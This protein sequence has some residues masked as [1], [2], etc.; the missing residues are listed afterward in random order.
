MLSPGETP[1]SAE[2]EARAAAGSAALAKA[3]AAGAFA[4]YE[5]HASAGG[6]ACDGDD[7]DGAPACDEAAEAEV[8]AAGAQGE[9]GEEEEEEAAAEAAEGDDAFPADADGDLAAAAADATAAFEDGHLLL[10]TTVDIGGGRSDRVEVRA[11]DDPLALARAFVERHGL[12]AAIVGALGRH[13]LD[14]LREAAAAQEA[15]LYEAEAAGNEEGHEEAYE[16][17]EGEY[18]EEEEEEGHEG[19]G[20]QH[21]HHLRP[22]R[23]EASGTLGRPRRAGSLGAARSGALVDG[24]G[25]GAAGGA[26][27]EVFERLYE[28]AVVLRQKLESRRAVK[29][30][31]DALALRSGRQHMGWISSEMM[32]QRNA[33]PYGNYGEM[34]YAESLEG[35]ARREQRAARERAERGEAEAAEATFR[36][37]ISRLAQQL[38]TRAE[39]AAPAWQRL[40]KGELAF[41]VCARFVFRCWDIV[42][43]AAAVAH[44]HHAKF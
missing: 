12:P 34:L 24:E 5:Q 41:C 40:S 28:H 4:A 15:A 20:H 17:E 36:P 16:Q 43:S 10:V 32:R 25:S 22:P 42:G 19:G 11:G 37:E 9:E 3:A 44:D 13:L 18:E 33:G 8:N 1:T 39:G 38:W 35:A 31:E 21:P 23:G 27:A 30:A 2:A 14:N 26:D 6:L 7:D 29:E